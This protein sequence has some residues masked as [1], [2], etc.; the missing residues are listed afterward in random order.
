MGSLSSKL[1]KQLPFLE[2]LKPHKAAYGLGL[3]ALIMVDAINVA[4][5]IC[6]KLGIDAIVAKS[7]SQILYAG[8]GFFTLM[9]V[10][11][12]GRYWW[13]ILLIGT[14]YEVS[15]KLRL[16]LYSHLQKLGSSE[17]QK[18]RSGDL[19]SRA[20]NDV[21]S[22]RM[23]VG[24]GIL[25]TADTVILF[26]L[27]TPAMFW[28]SPKLSLFAFAFLPVVPWLTKVLGQ[29]IDDLFENLQ[30][31]MSRMSAF[32][33]EVLGASRLIKGAVLEP[34]V[35]KRF[36]QLAE[37]YRLTANQQARFQSMLSP[38][39]GLFN[40]LGTL[41]ILFFGGRDVFTGALSLGTFVAFQRFMFQLSWPM[42]AIGWAVTMSREGRAAHRRL[43]S[44]FSIKPVQS[45]Y[46][47]ATPVT[48]SQPTLQIHN[49]HFKYPENSHFNLSVS[50]LILKPHQKIGIVGPIGAGKTTL[51]NL[52]QRLVEPPRGTL[53]FEGRD[54]LS[55]PL[56]QLRSE[57]GCVEQQIFLFAETIE[58][59]LKMG[60]PN[61][62]SIATSEMW[63][64]LETANMDAEI[65][66]LNEALQAILGEKGINLSGGQKQRIA[67]A[68]AF[69]R[70]PKLLL[71]DDCFSAVD[72]DIEQKIIEN[73]LKQFP[74]ITVL[75]AS[76]RLSIMPELDEIWLINKGKIEATGNHPA[77]LSASPLY[78]ALWK[79]MD[80]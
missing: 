64:K 41:L 4:L 15:K 43:T 32:V 49:L 73:F 38:T 2:Y 77:L 40:G 26:L 72:P 67:L 13:R 27:I 37:D 17:L 56:P 80:A 39:L 42:E 28:L 8:V 20:T 78:Q 18:L 24:P 6:L 69:L 54:V 70:K 23:A 35:N 61:A 7:Y 9:T 62:A 65:K 36:H 55:I 31:K 44:L 48:P 59:N 57:I 47:P 76:H 3:L 50:N 1:L 30:T 22:V 12:W 5:P 21:E 14:S 46:F 60:N 29:K 16:D 33:Q 58:K 10:Q 19:M 11:A 66:Q 51:F 63:E 52:I 68:R 75:V 74:D 45:V 53:F 25:V 34:A 79:G 71:L